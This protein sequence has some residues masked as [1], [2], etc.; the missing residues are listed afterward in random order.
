MRF[1][2]QTAEAILEAEPEARVGG[3]AL[4]SVYSPILPVLLENCHKRSIPIHF[5]SWHIYTS[6][7]LKVRETIE[8]VK[9]LLDKWY[10]KALTA[11]G[12]NKTKRIPKIWIN[13]LKG[14]IGDGKQFSG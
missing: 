8:Y 9:K 14:Y 6:N 10:C 12:S 2:K 3:P 7:P 5:V 13:S 4:A 1:Y 11:L